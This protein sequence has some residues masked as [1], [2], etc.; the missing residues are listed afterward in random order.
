MGEEFMRA[1]GKE[2]EA[3]LPLLKH[4]C[5]SF[6]VWNLTRDSPSRFA[7]KRMLGFV[8]STQPTFVSDLLAAAL[9]L[10]HC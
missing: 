5:F 4:A 8:T 7:R 10:S 1:W 9:A 6:F 3:K 2:R